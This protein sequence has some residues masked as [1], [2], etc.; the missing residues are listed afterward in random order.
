MKICVV[1]TG[2]V[3]L[4]AGTCLAESG[5]DVI[6][7]DTDEEKVKTLSSGTPTIY[8]PGLNEYLRRNLREKRLS[9]TTELEAAV[10]K[11]GIV[12][13]AVGTPT[14]PD[15]QVDLSSVMEVAEQ[16][17]K[18]LEEYT[19]VVIKST[20]PVGTAKRVKDVISGASGQ[21]FSVVSNPE[22]LK[23]GAA[24]DDFMKPD[25]VIL[26]VNPQET[27]VIETMRELYAP[28]LRTGKP[29]IVMSH[30][31]AE[32]CKYACN[33][34]LAA[35][36][37]FMNEMANFCQAVGADINEVRK[38]MG[39][40]PRIG[41]QFLFPGVG[42]G[43]S[44]F[45]K[46]ITALA[47]T[48][49]EAGIRMDILEAVRAVNERQKL[50]LVERVKE[51][52]GEDLSGTKGAVWG[53]SFK[54]RTDDIREAPSLRIIQGLLEAGAS[55]N[56]FDPVAMDNARSVLG[57]TVEYA[58]SN[59]DALKDADFLVVVT[60]WNEFRRPDFSRVKQLMRQPVIF[61]GR[62]IFTR[63]RMEELGF[64]YYGIG[65]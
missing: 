40:D 58:L 51:H 29:L 36:I 48:A 18:A 1:G 14:G 28:F 10:K 64:T 39:T 11:S 55:L 45:P 49:S 31:S 4:V 38:G 32:L 26:G 59:Y 50:V 56:V 9:F 30:T 54:P 27:R 25:R 53:L 37:S 17:G 65:C 21:K 47:T 19:I 33:S 22:F 60:E 8:E 63:R 13:I 23:E 15:M 5:N 52:F 12:F 34:F 20:V 46:D 16:I 6:C 35:R 3:G 42:F 24:V 2:Y 57:E 43:G 41:P 61:D 7:V 62:N 44:C